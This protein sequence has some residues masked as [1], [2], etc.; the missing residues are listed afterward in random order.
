VV[1]AALA[2]DLDLLFRFVDGK[3]H[4]NH[5]T[6]SLTAA[7]LAGLLAAAVL[8]ALQVARASALGLATGLAWTTHVV[9][10]FLNRDTNPPIGIMALWPWSD[11]F[12][13]VPWPIFL[14]I[15]RRLD[16]E[17]LVHNLVAAAWEGVVL[18]PV[19]W[20]ALRYRAWKLTEG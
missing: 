15:G 20:A 3:N 5:E 13:K 2:P 11:D 8:R 6:H 7:I 12:Y 4:H 9:L 1:G 18:V 16:V 14:D 17:T 10:D 19:L